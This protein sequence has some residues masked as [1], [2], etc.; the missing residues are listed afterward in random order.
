MTASDDGRAL[1][2]GTPGG[3]NQVPWNAQLLQGVIDGVTEPGV[4][5]TA[6]RWEGLPVDDGVRV[7]DGFAAV[8]RDRL[9]AAAPR[10]V[11]VGRWALPC[12][13]QVV[14]RP[15]A[16]EAIVG[17]ADPRTVGLALGV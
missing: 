17:A 13:Q 9:G 7:E 16:G 10:M 1:L 2:G 12:A 8:Q 3:D 6:P 4:L 5:V 11:G 15:V 14:V